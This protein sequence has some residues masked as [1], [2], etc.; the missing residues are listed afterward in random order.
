MTD[1]RI[2]S[3]D[4][5]TLQTVLAEDIDFDGELHFTEPLL[6]KGHVKGKVM[7][8]T[9]LYINA[10]AVV[11]ARIEAGKVSVKGE[12][13]GDIYAKGRVELFASARVT[14]NV[15]TPDLIVQSGCT[16]NGSCTMPG[17]TS[18]DA[19]GADAKG[20]PSEGKDAPS[21]GGGAGA[22]GGRDA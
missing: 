18:P 9:D 3:I 22:K 10:D 7:S 11:A 4:E 2:R 14:G 17:A 6:I 5:S 1:M 12:V 13:Q 8:E 16:L 19:G 21:G 20:G 15:H